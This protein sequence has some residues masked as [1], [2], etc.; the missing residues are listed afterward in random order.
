MGKASTNKKI[1]RAAR[2]SGASGAKK[3]YAWPAAIGAVV[4]LGVL[5]VVMSFQGEKENV[6]PRIGDHWHAAYGVYQCD[7]YLPPIP[8]EASDLSGIHTHGEG[9]MHIH[10]FSSRV[11][12]TG[13]NIGA[14]MDTEESK[15]T[16]TSI[17]IPPIGMDVKNGD[18]CGD[19]PGT[20]QLVVWASPSA[21]TS[22]ILTENLADYNPPD[23]SVWA[24]AFVADGTTV[25]KPDSAINLEDPTAA[26]EGRQPAT[27]TT[28]PATT[29]TTVPV[30]TETTVAPATTT[31]TAAP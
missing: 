8:Q 20:V 27:A 6:A 23:G 7:H 3:S 4:L 9:L 18:D 28:Q 30:T 29:P 5:L 2:V 12:G 10:P 25:P 22:T 16:D 13:A 11:T 26:E 1:A 31:T 21:T 24:L 15:V 19:K 14:F 17:D